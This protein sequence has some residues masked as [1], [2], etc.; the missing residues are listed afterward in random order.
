[1]ILSMILTIDQA[2]NNTPLDGMGLSFV[3]VFT[4]MYVISAAA[5]L[6]FWSAEEKKSQAKP[7]AVSA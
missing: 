2:S 3:V 4:A 6:F 5:Q 7:Y 1:M